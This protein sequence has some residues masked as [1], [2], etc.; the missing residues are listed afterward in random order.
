MALQMHFSGRQQL[1]FCGVL[2]FPGL[3]K[4]LHVLSTADLRDGTLKVLHDEALR[5]VVIDLMS[6]D[7]LRN[8]RGPNTS[9]SSNPRNL[10]T[11]R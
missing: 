3:S 5:K 11:P 9:Q 2:K 8:V 1:L 6:S 7:D 10:N 4:V